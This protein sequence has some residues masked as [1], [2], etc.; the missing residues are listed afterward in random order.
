MDRG[1]VHCFSSRTN[2][3]L[4]KSE[5]TLTTPTHP[6]WAARLKTAVTTWCGPDRNSGRSH[7]ELFAAEQAKWDTRI[8]P[9]SLQCALVNP[10]HDGRR[11]QGERER[12][13]AGQLAGWYVLLDVEY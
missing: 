6:F 1:S 13:R 3:G 10:A 8:P 9:V 2:E 7:G 5:G 11:I 4:P 12:P